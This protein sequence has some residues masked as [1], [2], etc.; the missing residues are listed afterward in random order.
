MRNNFGIRPHIPYNRE[1]HS[2]KQKALGN[3]EECMQEDSLEDEVGGGWVQP[4]ISSY[5]CL[6]AGAIEWQPCFFATIVL[7]YAPP[8]LTS[9]LRL[10]VI[11]GGLFISL[12]LY[13]EAF[14]GFSC[15]FDG[16]SCSLHFSLL[17]LLQHAHSQRLGGS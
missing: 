4:T 8:K 7:V 1:N 5:N 9:M 10:F 6:S 15:Y 17:P 13:R 12:L 11:F 2:S 3:N 16:L 14:I